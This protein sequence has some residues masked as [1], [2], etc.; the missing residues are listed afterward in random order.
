LSR[1]QPTLEEVEVALQ[2][3]NTEQKLVITGRFFG[4]QKIEELAQVLGKQPG[5]I[6]VM[7]FR[8]LETM[9]AHLGSVRESRRKE[10]WRCISKNT[11]IS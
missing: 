9:A 10:E 5:A 11:L 2:A 7:Q 8:A 3:L 6:R 1:R 4:G